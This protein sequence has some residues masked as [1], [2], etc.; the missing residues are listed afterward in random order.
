MTQASAVAASPVEPTVADPTLLDLARGGSRWA[1]FGFVVIG[2]GALIAV[3]SLTVLRPG[4]PKGG[5]ASADVDGSPSFKV[6]YARGELR[7]GSAPAGS[8]LLV[9]RGDDPQGSRLY[10]TPLQLAAYA[11]SPS[12]AMPLASPQARTTI[13]ARFDAGSVS[14]IDEGLVNVGPNPGY[15]LSYTAKRDGRTWFGRAAI[16]V[17]DVDGDR[18]AVLMD[19]EEQLVPRGRITGP[20]AVGRQG[21]LR[22]PMRSLVFTD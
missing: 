5:G 20:R 14:W 17:P 4:K 18:R 10:V 16:V 22:R 8:L 3:A 6:D 21:D 13:A 7:L 2:A 15:Q 12:G 11:G 9:D 19:G 1:R